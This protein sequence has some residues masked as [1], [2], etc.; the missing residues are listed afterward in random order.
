MN[1]R[2]FSANIESCIDIN[3]GFNQLSD[4]YRI[5]FNILICEWLNGLVNDFREQLNVGNHDRIRSKSDTE[6]AGHSCYIVF[7]SEYRVTKK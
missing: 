3:Y 4:G 1:T 5:N 2:P 6:N 7:D